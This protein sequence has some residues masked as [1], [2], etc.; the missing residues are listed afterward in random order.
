MICSQMLREQGKP[1]PRTCPE[2]FLGPCKHMPR[3]DPA[4]AARSDLRLALVQLHYSAGSVD[5]VLDKLEAY[6][7]AREK[8]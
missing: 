7:T 8:R 6:L 5:E 2:C 3:V 1:Y 4:A